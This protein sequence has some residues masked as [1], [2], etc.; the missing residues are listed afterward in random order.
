MQRDD[1]KKF[2]QKLVRQLG[3]AV[4][5][6][7]NAFF[8]ELEST[9]VESCKRFKSVVC[10]QFDAVYDDLDTEKCYVGVIS[11]KD[12]KEKYKSYLFY[13]LTNLVAKYL[14]DVW[15][16]RYDCVADDDAMVNAACDAL[17][18]NFLE[19]FSDHTGINWKILRAL[20]LQNYEGAKFQGKILFVQPGD[21]DCVKVPIEGN[22][23]II[24]QKKKSAAFGNF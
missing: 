17:F 11:A 19:T 15:Q 18:E 9:P 7:E 12:N 4:V 20:S 24:F 13:E 2:S 5:M 8:F 6:D 14:E 16:D 3:N 1:Y 22:E 10:K 21:G 23:E